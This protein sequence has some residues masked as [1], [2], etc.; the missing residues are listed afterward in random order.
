MD[1]IAP[2]ASSPFFSPGIASQAVPSAGQLAMASV[3]A[4]AQLTSTMLGTM[5]SVDSVTSEDPMLSVLSASNTY[6]LVNA[7]GA[8]ALSYLPAAAPTGL[9]VNA[10]A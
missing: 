4:D 10:S 2:A 8:A 3:S 6:A 9:F 5:S 7:D 1:S